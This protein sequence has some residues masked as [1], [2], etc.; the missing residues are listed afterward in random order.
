MVPS[1]F[2]SLA[3]RL[4]NGCTE[5]E[6][7][8]QLRDIE[9]G[10]LQQSIVLVDRRGEACAAATLLLEP[11]CLRGGMSAAHVTE[12]L[13][14]TTRE[15]AQLLSELAVAAE[16]AGA[17]KAI[18]DAP[19]AD[20][21]MLRYCG[22]EP[23]GLLMMARLAAGG[24]GGAALPAAT[25]APRPL[26]VHTGSAYASSALSL[27]PLSERDGAEYVR[28]LAQ[29]SDAPPLPDAVYLRQLR[30]IRAS[31]AHAVLVV[32]DPGSD[33]TREREP[34]A[35]P[36]LLACATMLLERQPMQRAEACALVARIEDVVVDERARG[37]GLGRSLILA[38][39]DMS[40]E[41]GCGAATL[42]CSADREAFYAKCGFG[43][44]PAG[45][46][47]FAAYFNGRGGDVRSRGASLETPAPRP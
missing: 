28:L 34:P 16:A 1:D 8:A 31:N 42:N 29:L 47:G 25:D 44:A 18:I 30:A 6:F 27:R 3:R 40:A 35:P 2:H 26:R 38:L 9:A 11:K 41:L 7:A 17:Y 43:R 5:Q 12:L 20:D 21:G 22:F 23:Q 10:G 15:R 24:K 45:E 32:D 46:V 13:P 39:L 14:A 37:T 33:P 19:A 4:R 36:R